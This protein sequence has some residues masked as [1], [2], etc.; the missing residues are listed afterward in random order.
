MAAGAVLFLAGLVLLVRVLRKPSPAQA[1]EE[2]SPY[3]TGRAVALSALWVAAL[4]AAQI[5]L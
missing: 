2:P 3:G 5:V 1:V 4:A